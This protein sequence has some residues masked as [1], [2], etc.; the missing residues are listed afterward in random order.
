[1][2]NMPM[3]GKA[4]HPSSWAKLAKTQGYDRAQTK[5]QGHQ[6]REIA[7]IIESRQF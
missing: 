5:D 7:V 1:M 4:V 2:T 6:T 3:Q